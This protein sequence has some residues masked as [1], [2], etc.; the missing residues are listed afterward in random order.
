MTKVLL[1]KQMMELFSFFW[2]DKKKNKNR[3]G[4]SLVMFLMLYVVLFGALAV[5]FYMIADPL[6]EPLAGAG[7]AWLYFSLMGLMGICKSLSGKG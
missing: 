3:T 7:M 4:I 2:Q 6:C 1:K 5:I